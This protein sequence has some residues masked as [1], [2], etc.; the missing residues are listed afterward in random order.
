VLVSSVPEEGPRLTTGINCHMQ[1]LPK[2][3]WYDRK[4]QNPQFRYDF[5]AWEHDTDVYALLFL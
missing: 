2:A 4:Y 3:L 1:N 5:L